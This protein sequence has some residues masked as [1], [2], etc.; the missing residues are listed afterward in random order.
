MS[1]GVEQL[2]LSPFYN[3]RSDTERNARLHFLNTVLS[4]TEEVVN[5]T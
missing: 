2:L 1:N 3:K 5:E 4:P